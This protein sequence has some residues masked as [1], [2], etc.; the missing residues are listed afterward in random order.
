MARTL[1]LVCAK[2]ESVCANEANADKDEL[3]ERRA[4]SAARRAGGVHACGSVGR[5]V[6]SPR[7][8]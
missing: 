4:S 7:V 1:C 2:V 5:S 8:G 3:E 6:G